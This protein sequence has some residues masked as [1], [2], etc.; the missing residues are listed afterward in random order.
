MRENT[1]DVV[2]S[3]LRGINSKGYGSIESRDGILFSY[4]TPIAIIDDETGG[5]WVNLDSYSVTT[6]K[7]QSFLKQGME[8]IGY[9]PTEK[10]LFARHIKGYFTRIAAGRLHDET[11]FQLWR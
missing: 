7:Q 6:S 11:E 9:K 1:R 3:F 8:S 5:I 4:A 2:D 10:Y